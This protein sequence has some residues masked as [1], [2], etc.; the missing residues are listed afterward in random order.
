ML[1]GSVSELLNWAV[2]NGGQSGS[3][4]SVDHCVVTQC[5]QVDCDESIAT[6]VLGQLSTL[7]P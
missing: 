7:E 6:N 3:F 1:M 2:Y 4:A 5:N